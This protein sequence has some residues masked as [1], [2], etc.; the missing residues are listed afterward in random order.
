MDKLKGSRMR[1]RKGVLGGNRCDA[2]GGGPGMLKLS[3]SNSGRTTEWYCARCLKPYKLRAPR[4][5][6][7]RARAPRYTRVGVC[8]PCRREVRAD[9]GRRDQGGGAVGAVLS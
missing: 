7:L 6:E 1:R 5:K 9:V 2:R 3:Y 4:D 8:G